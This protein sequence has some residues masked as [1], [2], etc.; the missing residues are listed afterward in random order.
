LYL[1]CPLRNSFAPVPPAPRPCPPA[2]VLRS[3]RRADGSV[4]LELGVV[5]DRLCSAL[6]ITGRVAGL[7]R[8]VRVRP[9]VLTTI[10]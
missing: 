8:D 2:R 1:V 5:A 6:V 7:G 4:M 3:R 9:T 10:E